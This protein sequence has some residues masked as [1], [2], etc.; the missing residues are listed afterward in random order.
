MIIILVVVV[1]VVV[2]LSDLLNCFE[3]QLMSILP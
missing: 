1:V 2:V 3:V